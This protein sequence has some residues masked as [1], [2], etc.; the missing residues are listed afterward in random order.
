MDA[1]LKNLE[2]VWHGNSAE[3]YNYA[4]DC[5][6]LISKHPNLYIYIL[7]SVLEELNITPGN[8]MVCQWYW[9]IDIAHLSEYI[10]TKIC[11][12]CQSLLK[13][14]G[15]KRIKPCFPRKEGKTL[16]PPSPFIWFWKHRC[17]YR[18][19]IHVKCAMLRSSCELT[20]LFFSL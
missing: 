18:R 15:Y 14:G 19:N 13:K 4:L 7:G 1:R 6:K 11:H 3:G 17:P 2:Y 5:T 20:T 16:P 12:V 10:S 8:A 9:D